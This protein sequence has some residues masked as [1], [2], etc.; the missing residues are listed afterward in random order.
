ML[1]KA[2]IYR[3]KMNKQEL[4][5]LKNQVIDQF[6]KHELGEPLDWSDKYYDEMLAKIK[7]ADPEF[8]I[9]DF[10]PHYANVEYV[11]HRRGIEELEKEHT[12]DIKE[13]WDTPSEPGQHRLPKWDGS[14]LVVYYTNGK[15]WRIVSMRDKDAGCDV[16]ENFIGFV[17]N[18]I[19][20]SVSFLRCECL[21]DMRLDDNARGKANGLVNSDYKA[22]EIEE[23]ATLMCFCAHDLSGKKFSYE[24]FVNLVPDNLTINRENGIP[25][26]MRSRRIEELTYG[27]KVA[28]YKD[29]SFDY[30]FA[31]DGIVYYEDGFA[32]KYDYVESAITE[33][34]EVV[35]NKTPREGW[36]STI[37]VNP[38][39]VDGADVYNPSS[40]GAN[41]LVNWKIGKGTKVEVVRSGLTIPKIINVIDPTGPD[42][43]V[44]PCGYHM[45]SEDIIGANFYCK[46]RDCIDKINTRK[47][48]LEDWIDREGGDEEKV[49][50]YIKEH[51]E[52]TF[53]DYLNTARFNLEHA[54]YL[55]PAFCDAR[56]RTFFAGD[57]KKYDELEHWIGWEGYEFTD[58]QWENAYL[59]MPATY[60]VLWD[61]IHGELNLND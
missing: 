10:E 9:H 15:L 8:E 13:I 17:P 44:C 43:P 60:N 1:P 6:V 55:T 48:W 35:W 53:F 31:I 4:V 51:L 42:L 56:F 39:E 18:V 14:S 28:M 24:E 36:F 19:D 29:E 57:H 58:L 22:T 25:K 61:F 11:Q 45:T 30:Q 49:R 12:H 59:F 7:S 41:N 3:I 20:K 2:S 47:E 21:V 26:F 37:N 46:N 40:N 50:D 33:V 27:D 32:Y 16:T 52:E 23:K 54:R 5:N 38:V 34:L